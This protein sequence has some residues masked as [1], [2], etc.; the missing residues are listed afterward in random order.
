MGERG[1]DRISPFFIPMGHRQRRRGP[2][3]H[4]VRRARPQLR[5][6]VGL[7]DRRPRAG[8]GL[9]DDPPRRRR[10]DDR[11]RVEGRGSTRRRWAGSPP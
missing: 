9:G 4:R 1:P 6:G 10:R 2:D 11:G 8:R 3:R 5:D 7:R